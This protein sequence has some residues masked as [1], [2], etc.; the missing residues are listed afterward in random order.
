[1]NFFKSSIM[2]LVL[3]HGDK[4]MIGAI[5]NMFNDISCNDVIKQP[6]MPFYYKLADLSYLWHF[7]LGYMFVRWSIAFGK[8]LVRLCK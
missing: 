8:M 5:K 1:I 6:V 2:G 4:Q 3:I 7:P